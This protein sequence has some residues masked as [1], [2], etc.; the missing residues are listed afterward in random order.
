M[1]EL[2]KHQIVHCDIKPDNIFVTPTGHVV[3]S[4]FDL[5][6]PDISAAME[7]GKSYKSAPLEYACGTPA[8]MAPE[9][10]N[11]ISNPSRR[12]VMARPTQCA[13]IW[14]LGVTLLQFALQLE[15]VSISLT[16]SLRP[17]PTDETPM[18][19]VL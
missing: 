12:G 5:S 13:D 8:Y 16:I 3:L 19:A 18:S 14:S 4:D 7:S 2:Q 6:Y 15:E 11:W 1:E 9:L 17:T 10:L